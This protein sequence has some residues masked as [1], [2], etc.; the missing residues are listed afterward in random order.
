M[1]YLGFHD[2]IRMQK[3]LQFLLG[4]LLFTLKKYRGFLIGP[5]EQYAGFTKKDGRCLVSSATRNGFQCIA[6][7]LNAPN[8]WNDHTLMLNY[9]FDNYVLCPVIQA[10]DY[11][12]T[13][14]VIQGEQQEIGVVAQSGLD[15][16]AKKGSVPQ[17][18]LDIQVPD[19]LD[20]P[21]GFEQPA[22]QVD[23]YMGEQKIGSVPAI[24]TGF[25]AKQEPK[26]LVQGLRQVIR[27]WLLLCTADFY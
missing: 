15:I 22:G 5:N 1:I 8:D 18:T 6:V 9:A 3:N 12:R 24:T 19:S 2:I 23:V 16:P 4:P 14:A 25:V 21:V 13:V 10:G 11:L 27:E 7:T 20:A 17:V 26:R